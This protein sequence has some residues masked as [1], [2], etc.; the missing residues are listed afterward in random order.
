MYELPIVTLE[1]PLYVF[2]AEL[3]RK[4]PKDFEAS[5]FPSCILNNTHF[6]EIS[7]RNKNFLRCQD[8]WGHSAGTFI[9]A[10][11]QNYNVCM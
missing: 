1:T 3:Y 10:K 8:K 5:G 2:R 11:C 4:G 7:H 9:C 6:F